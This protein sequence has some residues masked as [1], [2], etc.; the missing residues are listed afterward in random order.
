MLKP[1]LSF[2]LVILS[3]PFLL[4]LSVIGRGPY[5]ALGPGRTGGLVEAV[6]RGVLRGCHSIELQI[7]QARKEA[8]HRDQVSYYFELFVMT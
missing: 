6:Y 5:L 1:L 3:V 7:S 8:G 4:R 2:F